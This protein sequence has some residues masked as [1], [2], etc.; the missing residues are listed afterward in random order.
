[1]WGL[2]SSGFRAGLAW[3]VCHEAL[4]KVPVALRWEFGV[5]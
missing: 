5:P 4:D 2:S 1:M 3:A